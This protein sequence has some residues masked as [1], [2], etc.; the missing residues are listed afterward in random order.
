MILYVNNTLCFI[1]L[2]FLF[3]INL[4]LLRTLIKKYTRLLTILIFRKSNLKIIF[5]SVLEKIT[6]I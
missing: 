5:F 2:F 4:I 3:N 6:N 1:I